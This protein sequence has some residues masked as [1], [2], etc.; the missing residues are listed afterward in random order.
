M[1]ILIP[2]YEPNETLLH[3]ITELKEKTDYTVLVVDDGSGDNYACLFKKAE[4]LGS[5]VLHHKENKGKGAALKTGFDYVLTHFSEEGV[6]C[7][8]SDGQH[9][10]EDII[11]VAESIDGS[12][13]EMILGV[14][15]FEDNVPLKS[16][17]GNSLTAF[18][19]ASLTK[20][21]LSDTQTGLR[22]YPSSM[23]TWLLAVEGTRFEYEFNLLLKAKDAG[24]SVR[25]IPIRTIYENNNKGTHFHPI[26]DSVRVYV[27]LLKFSFSSLASAIID[28]ILLFV[29]Q[30]ATGSLFFGVVLARVFSSVFNYTVNRLL[31]FKVSNVSHTQSAPKYF[32]LVLVM[33]FLN[34][35]LLA[36]LTKFLFVPSV[37]AK[38]LTEMTLFLLSYSVQKKFVFI[39]NNIKS[40]FHFP[41]SI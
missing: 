40:V 6:V 26:R 31:V 30:A 23:L 5:T 25:Q 32:S 1:L 17:L 3:V 11:R 16:R 27:P 19:F 38:I 12:K 29:F 35:C 36:L 21:N 15:Q 2:S 24:I 33:M 20:I 8:D 14:R 10:T 22:G 13:S 34:Y 18:L 9:K 7:A 39:Q 37:L 4:E 28:F 41:N